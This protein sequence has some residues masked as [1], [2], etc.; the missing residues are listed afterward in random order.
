[1]DTYGIKKLIEDFPFLFAGITQVGDILLPQYPDFG[2]YHSFMLSGQDQDGHMKMTTLLVKKSLENKITIPGLQTIPSSFYIPHIRGF[3]SKTP[4]EDP[5]MSSSWEEGTLYLGSGPEHQGL[6]DRIKSSLAKFDSAYK[7]LSTRENL[8]LCALDMVKYIDFFNKNSKINFNELIHEKEYQGLIANLEKKKT[9]NE[10][11]IEQRK[12]D[13]YLIDV[14]NSLGQ[15]NIKI[16]RDLLKDA[17]TDHQVKRKLVFEYALNRVNYVDTGL[18]DFDNVKPE[19][20]SF[21][22]VPNRAKV[23]ERKMNKTRWYHI[24]NNMKDKLIP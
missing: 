2:N 11:K 12:I 14:C 10:Q 3:K 4:G 17:I 8:K 18:W 22:K 15:D 19:M 16:V 5:K 1:L 21:W 23:D 7:N 20:P 24:I 6:E 9:K 13:N